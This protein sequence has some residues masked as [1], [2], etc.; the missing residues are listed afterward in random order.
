[1]VRYKVTVVRRDTYILDISAHDADDA[2][3]IALASIEQQEQH[4]T[5]TPHRHEV[6]V[7]DVIDMDAPLCEQLSKQR[8]GRA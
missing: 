1:M 4:Q 5:I 2:Q 3:K 8:P 7:I 6:Q